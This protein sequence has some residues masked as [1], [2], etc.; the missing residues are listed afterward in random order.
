M[1]RAPS[2]KISINGKDDALQN[3]RAYYLSGGEVELPPHQEE[4]RKRLIAAQAMLLDAQPDR[5]IRQMLVD[6]FGVSDITAYRD[7]R[8]A[9]SLFKDVRQAEKEGW[10]EIIFEFALE[11]YRLAREQED[12][13]AMAKA[14]REMKE[15]RGL[16]NADPDMPDFEKLLLLPT[17]PVLAPQNQ[18]LL[19]AMLSQQGTTDLSK[20]LSAMPTETI[21]HEQVIE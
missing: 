11:T 19:D 1:K 14:V 5:A 9:V 16:K 21:E 7:I 8:W 10:R 4:I 12:A 6:T 18:R 13:D 3:I 15:I 20:L 17:M 2:G